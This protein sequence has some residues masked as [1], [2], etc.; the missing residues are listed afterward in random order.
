ML[1]IF[2]V[3]FFLLLAIKQAL[4]IYYCK[5]QG[6]LYISSNKYLMQMIKINFRVL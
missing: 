1:P 2:T 4:F 6:I 3:S 5:G